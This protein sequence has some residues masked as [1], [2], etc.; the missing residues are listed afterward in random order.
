MPH[1]RA[2]L[3]ENKETL[4]LALPMIGGQLA[5]MLM[6]WADTIM[7]AR[8][9]VVPLAAAAF[10][11]TVIHVFLVFGFG[12]ISSVS[13]RASQEFGAER[14][15]GAGKVFLAGSLLG[16]LVGMLMVSLVYLLW[17]LTAYMGQDP[18]VVA[19]AK[20]FVLL[21]VWSVI[22]FLL[23]TV[24]KDFSEAL[25]RPW[26]PFW[27]ILS[28]VV[29]NVG[30]NWLLIY[31]N[32]GF[33]ALGLTGAGYGTLLARVIV[34][35]VLY[36]VI[37]TAPMYSPFR[38]FY[39]PI[40]RLI[41]ELTLLA[42]L[43]WPSGLHLLG[44]VGLF[45]ATMVMMGW[46][47]VSA[48]AAHQVAITC[49][50]TTFMIP[51]GLAFAVTVRVGQAVGARESERVRSIAL[52]ALGVTLLL[53]LACSVLF[54]TSGRWI[55]ASFIDDPQVIALSATLLM[56][57]GIFQLCDGC[58]IVGMGGLRGL[59]DVRRPMVYIYLCYWVVALPVGYLLAFRLGWGAAGVWSG[60]AIG[61]ALAAI[62]ILT[63]L[64]KMSGRIIAP[65]VDERG[66]QRDSI[67]P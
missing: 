41:S 65:V 61:L 62:L 66:D 29:L 23:T 7:V 32:W 51:L 53:M 19:H 17:P 46:I 15:K 26:L 6:G 34:L 45:A 31:G 42:R 67:N 58:Q 24:A 10:G 28:G 33:P 3:K 59:A 37:M 30:F 36:G 20:P 47:S 52:G 56:I 8:L 38:V 50:S 54:L 55:A 1:L 2:A 5:Q 16:L 4:W 39:V 12:L 43:G 63:R 60:L 35:V 40:R 21:L 48:L 27:I 49:A 64:W 44:E 14:P 9:G 18:E 13:I 22:P 11:L 25:S 57:A